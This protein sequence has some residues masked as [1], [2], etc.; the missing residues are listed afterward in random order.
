MH[1][2]EDELSFVVQGK[3]G[4][5][6]GDQIATAGPGSYIPKPRNIPNTLGTSDRQWL[7]LV[8]IISPPGFENFFDEASD[9]NIT[10]PSDGMNGVVPTQPSQEVQAE[11]VRAIDESSTSL[12][13]GVLRS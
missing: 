4:A 11:T 2:D 9:P 6:I 5:R 13:T 8:E 10:P 1:A 12:G 7:R 3:V